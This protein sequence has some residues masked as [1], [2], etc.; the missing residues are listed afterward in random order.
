MV[1]LLVVLSEFHSIPP[2]YLRSDFYFSAGTSALKV[3][4]YHFRLWNVYQSSMTT[5]AIS[6]GTVSSI[7][8]KIYLTM[9]V[10]PAN[11]I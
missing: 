7:L 4:I 8:S 5:R 6:R 2:N 1:M 3:F 9:F 11:E 10:G